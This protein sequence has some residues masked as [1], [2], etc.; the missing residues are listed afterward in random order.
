MKK[1]NKMFLLFL[2]LF[3]LTGIMSFTK[4]GINNPEK[5]PKIVFNE[6]KHDFGKVPQG[7]QLIYSFTFKNKGAATLVIGDIVTSCGC[8]AANVGEKKEYEKNEKGQIQVTFNT[9]GR[10]GHQ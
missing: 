9:Q 1:L 8:T 3:F 10:E 5:S 7:P 6:E 4:P 2:S